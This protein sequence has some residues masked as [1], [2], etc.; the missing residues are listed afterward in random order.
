MNKPYAESCD[1]NRD[2]ILAVLKKHL[3]LPMTVLEIGS[4]TGQHGVYFSRA[5]PHLQ[6]Q[7]SDRQEN[8]AGIS[9]WHKDAEL[10]NLKPP[11]VL[12]V[13]ERNWPS[14]D[15]QAVFSANTAHIMGW[16]AVEAMFEGIGKLLPEKG[17]FL[18][19]GPFNY[20]GKYTSESNKRFDAWLKTQNPT[21]GVRDFESLHALA[22]DN[23]MVLEEDIPMP[24]N[25]RILLWKKVEKH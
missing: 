1:Q 17:Y 21:R 12:D 14:L 7:L 23:S 8:I 13:S 9:M 3:A 20:N 18:L 2:P 15:V 19:Y 5:L 11:I 22:K 25:N 6:W 24:E 16:N 4:G 10:C